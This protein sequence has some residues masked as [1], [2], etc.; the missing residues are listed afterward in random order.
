MVTLSRGSVVS[1]GWLMVCR[2][3]PGPRRRHQLVLAFAILSSSFFGYLSLLN[4]GVAA[5]SSN[6]FGDVN[7][8]AILNSF[9]MGYDKRVRPNYGGKVLLLM[10]HYFICNIYLT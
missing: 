1:R 8:S 9:Q 10:A 4:M 5:Q 6:S 2:R 7:I 3:F